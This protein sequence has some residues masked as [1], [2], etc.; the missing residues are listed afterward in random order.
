[1]NSKPYR[2]I[3]LSLVSVA[4][5]LLILVHGNKIKQA[6]VLKPS[7]SEG[8]SLTQQNIKEQSSPQDPKKYTI[9][10]V[11]PVLLNSNR[12]EAFNE[13]VRSL[14][15]GQI[16]D[17]KSSL[18]EENIS[19]MLPEIQNATSTFII[20]YS[21]ENQSDNIISVLFETENSLVDSAHP[22]H[23]LASVN[24]DLTN[25][26]EL[27]LADIFKP[28]S[29][30]LS[31]IS[32]YCS[33]DLIKQIKAGIYASTEEYLQASSALT[34][35]VK[36]FTVFSITKQGLGIYFQEYEVGSYAAGS[37]EVLIRWEVIQDILSQQIL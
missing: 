21:I 31:V 12:A 24:F 4:V 32:K 8:Y 23:F 35:E 9:Q 17:F 18:N 27:S 34:P 28:N 11:Y 36:N 37:G 25:G 1:M 10:V 30:Y 14:I 29:D 7:V 5:I 15:E 6:E 13:D 19:L 33:D 16:T 2:A 3:I 22:W 26:K 20:D